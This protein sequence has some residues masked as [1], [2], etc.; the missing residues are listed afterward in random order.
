MFSTK[1]RAERTAAEAWDYLSSA[2]A[3]IGDN[4]VQA[5]KNSADV[6][7]DHANKLFDQASRRSSRLTD[8]ASKQ[9]SR[10]TDQASKQSSRLTDQAS[11]QS[12]LLTGQVSKLAGKASDRADEAWARANA[13]AAAL[14]GRKPGKP[15]GLIIGC[16]VLGI[17]LGWA[18]ASTV[19]ARLE[20]QA[21][22]E[23]RDLAHNPTVVA[24]SNDG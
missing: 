8:Q 2:M 4:A 15:W 24:G 9:S 18:A 13:A 17:A 10:L 22:N 19:R 14:S 16:S 23:E 12:H 20:R 1:N 7:T 6:A 21:A 5:S 3:A 11:K